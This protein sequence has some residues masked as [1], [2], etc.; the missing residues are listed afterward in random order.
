MALLQSTDETKNKSIQKQVKAFS[1]REL[2]L[3]G[4]SAR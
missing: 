4:K 3:Q 1:R 2:T